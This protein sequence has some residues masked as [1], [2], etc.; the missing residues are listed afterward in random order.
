MDRVYGSHDHDWLSVHGGLAIKE[1]CGCSGAHKV[2]MMARRERERERERGG[3]GVLTN[4]ATWRRGC[5]DGHTSPL[6][7]GG[8]WCS[9]GVMFLVAG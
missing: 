8:R 9:D 4:G 5:R 1:R 3:R 7:R 2:I 6:S